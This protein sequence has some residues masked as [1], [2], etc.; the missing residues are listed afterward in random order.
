MK[1]SKNVV[2]LTEQFEGFK[3]KM[4]H[5]TNGLPTIGFGTLIDSTNEQ[6]L[7][8]ET[9]TKEEAE[10]LLLKSYIDVENFLNKV[11]KVSLNQNQFDAISDFCYNCGVGNFK[12]SSLFKEIN[13]NPN[14]PDISNQFKKWVHGENGVVEGGLIKRRNLESDL[15]FKAI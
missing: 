6:H 13:I 12:K 14:N 7:L 15:Y 3:P 9:I 8:T 10:D 1:V 5:D 4:Y 11:L 2:V